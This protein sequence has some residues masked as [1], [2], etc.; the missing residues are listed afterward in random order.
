MKKE[1]ENVLQIVKRLKKLKELGKTDIEIE[2]II[3]KINL[4]LNYHL[5][6]LGNYSKLMN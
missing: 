5:Y 3:K 2:S 4:P 6:I 1:N